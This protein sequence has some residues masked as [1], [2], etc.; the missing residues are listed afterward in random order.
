MQKGANYNDKNMCMKTPFDLARQYQHYEVLLVFS[1]L[2]D[3]VEKFN[4]QIGSKALVRITRS[5]AIKRIQ[6]FYRTFK[7]TRN[8]LLHIRNEE[9]KRKKQ[10]QEDMKQWGES[11]LI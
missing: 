2:I 5:N 9:D 8:Y 10:E 6:K 7:L 11:P 3:A 1:R 4:E